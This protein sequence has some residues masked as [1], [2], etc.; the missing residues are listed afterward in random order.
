MTSPAGNVVVL[1]VADKAPEFTAELHPSG[2]VNLADFHGKK[3]VILAF[4][5][6]DSTPGCTTEMCAFSEDLS[7]FE[8][9]DTVVFGV[10]CDNLA[11]HE[12]FALKHN[13]SVPLIAD[14][15]GHV[16]QLYGSL[17]EGQRMANRKLFIIDKAGVIRHI[18][19]GMPKNA[20]LLEFIQSLS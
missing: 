7:R 8:S 13:L 15:E 10:S 6:K 5:P 18:H 9:A 19:D 14:P 20:V 11:S 4:Y 12:K 1:K 17:K 3:N 2:K 16:G